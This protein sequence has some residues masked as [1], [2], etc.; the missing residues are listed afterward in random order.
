MGE[1][2]VV[3]AAWRG[4][5]Q[6]P[7]GGN[8][9]V[10]EV[11]AACHAHSWAEGGGWMLSQG[12][13]PEARAVGFQ[14]P[15]ICSFFS[16]EVRGTNSGSAS[17]PPSKRIGVCSGER[18]ALGSGRGIAPPPAPGGGFS[19]LQ[20]PWYHLPALC[21]PGMALVITLLLTLGKLTQLKTIIFP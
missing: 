7:A 4:G 14:A 9:S 1:C 12:T 2:F 6:P 15:S 13:R 19:R 18:P 17:A 11:I 8:N 5:E 20:M 3:W 10:S 16:F 21:P